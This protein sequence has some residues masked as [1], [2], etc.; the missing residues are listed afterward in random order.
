[1]LG[2]NI[3]DDYIVDMCNLILFTAKWI[4]RKERNLVK[5]QQKVCSITQLFALF[6]SILTENLWY[7]MICEK[8][9]YRKNKM[10]LYLTNIANI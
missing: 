8:K 3:K 1:M 2:F 4:L 7:S 6:K 5:Y 10:K 9:L